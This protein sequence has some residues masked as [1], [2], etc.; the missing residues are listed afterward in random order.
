VRTDLL[1][2]QIPLGRSVVAVGL[3]ILQGSRSGDETRVILFFWATRAVVREPKHTHLAPFR[4]IMCFRESE[5]IRIMCVWKR[6]QRSIESGLL[7][8]TN[9]AYAFLLT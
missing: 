7:L 4:S 1:D 9:P 3:C 2:M 6:R 8:A 5:A